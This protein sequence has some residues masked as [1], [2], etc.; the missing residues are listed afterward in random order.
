MVNHIRRRGKRWVIF[1]NV[2]DKHLVVKMS[3]EI[4]LDFCRQN[5]SHFVE[6]NLFMQ[7]AIGFYIQIPHMV[8]TGLPNM[9]RT[10]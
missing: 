5:K 6:E 1:V 3:I 2:K 4:F 10:F 8:P 7:N 9:L